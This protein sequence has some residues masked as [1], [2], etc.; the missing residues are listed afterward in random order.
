MLSWTIK[1][2]P[3]WRYFWRLIRE[4]S[5]K[6]SIKPK[7]MFKVCVTTLKQRTTLSRILLLQTY[8]WDFTRTCDWLAISKSNSSGRTRSRFLSRNI[9]AWKKKKERNQRQSI[10]QVFLRNYCLKMVTKFAGQHRRPLVSKVEGL[11]LL[12][13][14]NSITGISNGIS[15]N[16]SGQLFYIILKS[17]CLYKV[18]VQRFCLKL[19]RSL[20]I[21]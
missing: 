16:F 18:R 6:S 11:P 7:N 17:G 20:H 4:F 15:R 9:S 3:N 1:C 21:L 10:P 5:F 14:N 13:K 8:F 12:L 19:G 2:R